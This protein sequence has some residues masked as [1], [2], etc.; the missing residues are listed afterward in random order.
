ELQKRFRDRGIE[1]LV[2]ERGVQAPEIARLLAALSKGKVSDRVGSLDSL[3]QDA[4]TW[5]GLPHIRVGRL[6]GAAALVET[7]TFGGADAARQLYGEGVATAMQIWE[8]AQAE[9]RPD[10][11][12]SR[13]MI[14]NVARGISQ[15]R[16]ALLALVAL[17]HYE[18]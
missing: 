10:P 9:K 13:T 16:T 15:N 7:P 6:Q 4:A 18:N 1:R 11:K 8:G 12:L 2:I 3:A 17:K 14:D 5:F